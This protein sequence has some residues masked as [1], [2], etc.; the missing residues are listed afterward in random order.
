[1]KIQK[2]NLELDSKMCFLCHAEPGIH[3]DIEDDEVM[4]V[5][6]HTEQV[7]IFRK[8]VILFGLDK[9]IQNA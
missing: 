5:R 7:G 1:M 3:A 8:E 6:T 4:L 9:N 2:L